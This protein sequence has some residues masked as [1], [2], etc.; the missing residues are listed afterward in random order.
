MMFDEVWREV[1]G[2]PDSAKMQVP[3][4]LSEATK[5]KIGGENTRR[6]CCNSHSSD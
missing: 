3:E 6:G 1:Q 5:K 4:V 2:L